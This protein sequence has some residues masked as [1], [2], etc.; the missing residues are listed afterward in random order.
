MTISI[1]KICLYQYQFYCIKCNRIWR[2]RM[3]V[4]SRRCR[5]RCLCRCLWRYRWFE[6]DA[7]NRIS[8]HREQARHIHFCLRV[9]GYAAY[10]TY[11]HRDVIFD[12]WNHEGSLQ[13]VLR[14]AYKWIYS[15]SL[16]YYGIILRYYSILYYYTI[17]SCDDPYYTSSPITDIDSSPI[18]NR[19]PI[20]LTRIS[21]SSWRRV[22]S[23]RS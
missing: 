3:A 5:C 17:I 14:S 9:E 10:R 21:S 12:N 16:R 23:A 13:M 15:P 19:W 18:S 1:I 2:R 20:T 4:N 6:A 7:H 22:K 8:I 11:I